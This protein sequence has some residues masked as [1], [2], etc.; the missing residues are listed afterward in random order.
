VP[1]YAPNKMPTEVKKRYFEL[2]RRGMKGAAAARIVGVSTSCGS[3]WFIDAG[4]MIATEPRAI[5]PRFLTQDD[6]IAIADGL[7]V[8]LTKHEI[9]EQIGKTFQTVYR[10]I[11][12]NSK[13]DGTYQPWWG[14][15]PGSAPPEAAQ[16]GQARGERRAADQRVGE[17]DGEV[18]P[19]ADRP[20]LGSDSRR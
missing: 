3:L 20:S 9:A 16:A 2:I 14:A 10:E 11:K 5:S 18:V 17:T 6:R 8:G 13:P 12:R 15:Q 19:A 4:S 1:R 7:R